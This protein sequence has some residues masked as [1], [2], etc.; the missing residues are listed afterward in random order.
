MTV[1]FEAEGDN[2]FSTESV[3]LETEVWQVA[4]VFAINAWPE[5]ENDYE[6]EDADNFDIVLGSR[7]RARSGSD[8]CLQSQ[9]HAA[10][11]GT[12]AGRMA[13]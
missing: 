12:N 6:N 11:H 5:G 3:I 10:V 13:V 2:H 7:R 9:Q 8:S 4:A 1:P